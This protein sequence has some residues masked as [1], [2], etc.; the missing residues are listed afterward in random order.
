MQPVWRAKSIGVDVPGRRRRT[1]IRPKWAL[2]K[3]PRQS[4]VLL[5]R[6][7]HRAARFDGPAVAHKDVVEDEPLGASDRSSAVGLVAMRERVRGAKSRTKYC[8]RPRGRLSVQ[9]TGDDRGQW[10]G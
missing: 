10:P 8:Q 5:G 3:R 1:G 9:V 2:G 4:R 7:A 6:D